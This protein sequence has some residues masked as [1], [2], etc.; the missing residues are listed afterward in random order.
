M[1]TQIISNS[2]NQRFELVSYNYSNKPVLAGILA[3]HEVIA[4]KPLCENLRIEYTWQ[5]RRILNDPTLSQLLL[6]D[7]IVTNG[8]T[9]EMVCFGFAGL[10]EWLWSIKPT[11]TMDIE[12]WNSYRKGLVMFLIQALGLS[13]K[14]LI[15]IQNQLDMLQSQYDD[16]ASDVKEMIETDQQ[17]KHHAQAA[18]AAFKKANTL[19]TVVLERLATNQMTIF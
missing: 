10:Q 11:P 18:K 13:L 9:R 2:S 1:I 5:Y 7:K 8:K 19:R 4:L 3:T 17:G 14:R 6:K 12:L 15:D 16:L